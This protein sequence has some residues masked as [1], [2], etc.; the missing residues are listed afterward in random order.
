MKRWYK[1][2][3]K[4]A[5]KSPHDKHRMAAVIIRAGSV[6]SM[7]PNSASSQWGTEKYSRHAEERAL[8]PHQNFEGATIVIA[9]TNNSMSR[10]CDYCMALIRQA[11]ISKI[12]Y[13][14]WT[15]N[16]VEERV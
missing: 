7:A 3:L 9:R 4:L 11:D 6:L 1:L 13:A 10:P 8:L 14:D 5:N 15:G 2:A 16:L 12:A